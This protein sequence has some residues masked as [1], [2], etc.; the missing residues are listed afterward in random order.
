MDDGN[1][2][3]PGFIVGRGNPAA[4]AISEGDDLTKWSLVVIPKGLGVG[5]MW[6]E[7]SII[8]DGPRVLNI[9]RF[10]A[11]P[12]ALAAASEDFGRTWTPSVESNLP[13]ATSK[14]ASGML[15]T[16]QRFLVCSTTAR[17][18]RPS[19]PTDHRGQPTGRSRV[20]ECLRHPPRRIPRRPPGESHSKSALSYPYAI[21]HDGKL[22]VGYSNSGGRGG[23]HNSAELAVV[24]VESLR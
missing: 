19:V 6:G 1:W 20:L 9:A 21:E 10:G 8:V 11:R 7:S 22:Y 18:W 12:L 14:P 24:P 16:G 13:M 2:I 23:N 3:L 5:N 4:V 17:W 15:S